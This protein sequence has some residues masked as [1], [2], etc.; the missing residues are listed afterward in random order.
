MLVTLYINT[1]P[2]DTLRESDKIIYVDVA[3]LWKTLKIREYH[4]RVPENLQLI[5]NTSDKS[6]VIGNYC[7]VIDTMAAL[8]AVP[9]EAY[10][11]PKLGDIMK[12][13]LVDVLD[14]FWAA[15]PEFTPIY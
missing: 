10:E 14:R 11:D 6:Y 7:T 3:K 4:V 13:A 15:Q 2:V 5:T 8:L 1:L 9:P 12:S